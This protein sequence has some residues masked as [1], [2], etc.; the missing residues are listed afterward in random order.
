L[1]AA[2]ERDPGTAQLDMRG[3]ALV[4]YAIKLTIA[5]GEVSEQDLGPLRDAGLS[6]RAIHDAASITAYFN[7][8]NAW[9]RA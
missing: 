6:D 2:L 1:L 9:R 4:D 5:P 8:V 3:R 7:F